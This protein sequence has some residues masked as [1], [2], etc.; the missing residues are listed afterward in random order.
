MKLC[1][2]IQVVAGVSELRVECYDYDLI[3]ENDFIGA[4]SINPRE[5]TGKRSDWFKLVHPDEPSF[6]AEVF[7]TL[8]P[9]YES[10]E[11][12]HARAVAAKSAVAAATAS[13]VLSIDVAAARGL[14]AMDSVGTS[15]PYTVLQVRSAGPR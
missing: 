6:N 10:A 9:A 2:F 1:L 11:E 12:A 15:D 13:T 5:I 14:A 4:V 7:L 3:G 8:T